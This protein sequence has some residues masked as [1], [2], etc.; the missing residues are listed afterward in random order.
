MKKS[1]TRLS[2]T[3]PSNSLCRKTSLLMLSFR[4][5]SPLTDTTFVTGSTSMTPGEK[6][7]WNFSAYWG[8]M[9]FSGLSITKGRRRY[10]AVANARAVSTISRWASVGTDRLDSIL[11]DLYQRLLSRG[12]PRISPVPVVIWRAQCFRLSD[13]VG[14]MQTLRPVRPEVPKSSPST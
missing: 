14:W 6:H 12:V 5:L 2:S 13:G 8:G 10:V 3:Q 11:H 4:M 1:R 7:F 9:G